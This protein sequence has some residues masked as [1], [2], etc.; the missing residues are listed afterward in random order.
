[1]RAARGPSPCRRPVE[2]PRARVNY[3]HA[4]HAGNFADVFKHILLA[5]MLVALARKPTPFRF[6]DT[7]AGT[8]WYDLTGDEATRGA[9]WADG[10]GRLVPDAVPT[11]L[12]E[13]LAPYLDAVG[14]RDAAGRPSGYPGSPAIAQALCRADDRIVC[15]ELHPDDAVALR[16]ALKGDKRAKAVALDGY[17]ALNAFVP[18]PE[19]RGLVLVD[20]PFEQSGEFDRMVAALETA[21]RKWPTGVYALWYPIKN[22]EAVL[23]FAAALQDGPV[24]RIAQVELVVDASAFARGALAGCGMVIVN[25]PFG[26]ETEAGALLP[27]LASRLARDGEAGS[28]RWRTLVP[29]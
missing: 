26:L 1:M 15:C 23:G 11:A 29:E 17:T 3:R 27:F 12:Q 9:E 22:R 5:R 7:H 13:L 2:G 8:A 18:P 10:I 6:L 21:W 4:F 19:R 14:P 20:P 24:Q 25:P 28:W 16:L